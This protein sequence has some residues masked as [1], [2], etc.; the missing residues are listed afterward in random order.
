MMTKNVCNYLYGSA[1]L[2]YQNRTEHI[3]L[4]G[5]V[6]SN[7]EVSISLQSPLFAV[8]SAAALTLH[9]DQVTFLLSCPLAGA[10]LAVTSTNTNR[11]NVVSLFDQMWVFICSTNMWNWKLSGNI[12]PQVVCLSLS[13]HFC[14]NN[15]QPVKYAVMTP[16]MP[17]N[18]MN[19]PRGSKAHIKVTLVVL[20]SITTSLWLSA[21]VLPETI[22]LPNCWSCRVPSTVNVLTL[23]PQ[24]AAA[25]ETEQR[26]LWRC[27]GSE[28][29][30]ISSEWQ[31]IAQVPTDSDSLPWLLQHSLHVG[32]CGF[33]L[34]TE[35]VFVYRC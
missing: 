27:W 14:Q 24:E 26:E 13:K 16:K 10:V 23:G 33:V 2:C 17:Y 20:Y 15:W 34:I 4:V 11:R 5:Y 29:A 12:E 9:S 22:D 28:T 18:I 32:F 31:K 30:K 35:M 21:S 25:K 3:Q 6:T 1:F 19:P 7:S 8:S